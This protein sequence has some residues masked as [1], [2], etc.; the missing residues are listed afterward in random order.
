MGTGHLQVCAL[1]SVVLA[2][3]V[4]HAQVEDRLFCQVAGPSPCYS[5]ADHRVV[6][7]EGGPLIDELQLEELLRNLPMFSSIEGLAVSPIGRLD[8]QLFL[9]RGAPLELPGHPFR[10][11]L[12]PG[13]RVLISPD[14]VYRPMVPST[15]VLSHREETSPRRIRQEGFTP[16][17]AE[18]DRVRLALL[19]D[20]LVWWQD[21][22]HT[23]RIES[24]WNCS[25]GQCREAGLGRGTHASE[26]LAPAMMDAL[27]KGRS[28]ATVL[29]VD[30][31]EEC[32]YATTASLAAGLS[33][34][35]GAMEGAGV[36][37]LPYSGACCDP[38]LA[39]EIEKIGGTIVVTGVP[40]KR[41]QDIDK[42]PAWPATFG[43]PNL[44]RVTTPKHAFGQAI[45]VAVS[46]GSSSAGVGYLTA[47]VGV[48]RQRHDQHASAAA[49][50]GAFRRIAVRDTRICHGV[51][52]PDRLPSSLDA[53]P[54]DRCACADP[55]PVETIPSPGP[56]F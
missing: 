9:V 27:R 42:L 5:R 11:Q 49:V 13:R 30:V 4:L 23:L 41:T 7:V 16:S 12:E 21:T 45:D 44:V 48:L 14:F 8:A 34:A 56:R 55:C 46:A 24:S 15:A 40:N 54:A 43:A 31:T 36:I 22:K 1:V 37:A 10:V 25:S 52:S 19:D 35:A 47:M 26:T 2:G 3:G 38:V 6:A 29:D 53:P 50:L 20:G 51:V 28:S 18:Q 17:S 39:L 33:F 32:G